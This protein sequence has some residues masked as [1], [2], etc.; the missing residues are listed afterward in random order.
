M[1]VSDGT[2]NT[3][4]DKVGNDPVQTGSLFSVLPSIAIHG[5]VVL[6]IWLGI[7]AD[8]DVQPPVTFIS[9]APAAASTTADPAPPAPV[10]PA[11]DLEP[12]FEP[13]P[14]PDTGMVLPQPE[15]PA[16]E[17]VVAFTPPEAPEI[18][19]FPFNPDATRPV[20]KPAP[21]DAVALDK[22]EEKPKPKEPEKKPEKQETKKKPEAKPKKET[23]K[24]AAAK[25]AESKPAPT[26]AP[27]AA[28][29]AQPTT[30]QA[31]P[32][33]P[34]APKATQNAAVSDAPVRITNPNYAGACPISYPER[35]RK[36]NQEGTVVVHALI[37]PDGKPIEVTV[38]Q[39]SG[40]TLLDEA[41]QA[42]IANCA[43]VPQK[44]GGRAVRAIVEIPIPFKLI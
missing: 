37:G 10:V 42:A 5:A 39:S 33:K 8:E 26:P 21:E 34:A 9:L 32:A 24:A 7:L 18:E 27:A 43:F 44:V 22:V 41:A 6:V 20:P 14:L 19:S 15:P 31:A 17:P 1:A 13:M 23:R 12:A 4:G 40:H 28:A 36:R 25:V 3:L 16:P 29:P 2:L 30:A 35:A 11:P 38:A